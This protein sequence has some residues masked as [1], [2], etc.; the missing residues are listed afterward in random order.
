MLHKKE[1]PIP[2]TVDINLLLANERTLLAWVRTS[3]ALIGG[4][5]AVA[6]VTHDRASGVL[7]GLAAIGFG[8][9][10]SVIG[11]V[12]FRMT[13]RSIREGSVPGMSSSGLIVV[14]AVLLFA[15]ALLVL[16]RLL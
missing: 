12:R 15:A 13:D 4:G 9:V 10:L 8:G 7:A 5:V 11:Y 3:L 6:F 14:V 2:H 1:S 16:Y